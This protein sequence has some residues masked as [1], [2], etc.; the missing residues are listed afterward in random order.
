MYAIILIFGLNR[1]EILVQNAVDIVEL[2]H[3]YAESGE[4]TLSQFIFWNYAPEIGEFVADEW[5]FAKGEFLVERTGCGW[6]VFLAEG[7]RVH[8]VYAN[9]IKTSWTTY[10]R[11]RHNLSVA[12][13]G[14]RTGLP[15]SGNHILRCIVDGFGI[16]EIGRH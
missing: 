14:F 10:D 11:E 8:R 1:T 4:K 16:P 2:N 3:V 6:V 13:P 5:M 12:A 15:L 9:Q 7:P